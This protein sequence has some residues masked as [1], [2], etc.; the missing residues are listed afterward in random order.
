M[1]KKEILKRLDSDLES[2]LVGLKISF[3]SLI[4]IIFLMIIFIFPGATFSEMIS[5][6]LKM[7]KG[8]DYLGIFGLSILFIVL[9]FT[10]AVKLK[11]KK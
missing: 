6:L 9:P 3:F 10:M 1:K 11:K 2:G 8:D 7:P 4:I 5:Y